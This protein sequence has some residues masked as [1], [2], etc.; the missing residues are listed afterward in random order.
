MSMVPPPPSVAIPAAVAA[1]DGPTAAVAT[2]R[3][4]DV[5]RP[6]SRRT[7]SRATGAGASHDAARPSRDESVASSSPEKRDATPAMR[8]RA[9]TSAIG[10]RTPT[11]R[12]PHPRLRRV[13]VYLAILIATFT[14]GWALAHLALW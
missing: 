10:A 11:E 3:D 4:S 2:P 9:T 5:V 7:K 13:P 1:P 12:S 14:L 8:D 6:R